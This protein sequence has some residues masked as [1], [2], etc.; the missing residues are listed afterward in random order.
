[1]VCSSCSDTA[2][3]V[4]NSS[5][6]RNSSCKT[7]S[8][9]RGSPMSAW[10]L[11]PTLVDCFFSSLVNWRRNSIWLKVTTQRKGKK[12]TLFLE[13]MAFS[14]WYFVRIFDCHFSVLDALRLSLWFGFSC[15]VNIHQVL[16]DL[17]FNCS[18]FGNRS[19]KTDLSAVSSGPAPVTAVVVFSKGFACACGQSVVYLFEKTDDKDS[20]RK[21][22]RIHVCTAA[23]IFIII[24]SSSSPPVYYHA[25]F[26]KKS[27]NVLR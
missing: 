21:T 12:L 17:S 11:E 27:G 20:Y 1:M 16:D 13:M 14:G 10:S 6:F 19:S 25:I 26:N 18:L 7:T 9:S 22:R 2:R 24:T 4:S 3:T 23:V 5:D 8:A 15:A